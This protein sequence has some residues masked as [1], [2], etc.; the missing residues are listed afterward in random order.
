VEYQT[1]YNALYWSFV[2]DT[3]D[4][5]K[6]EAEKI[7]ILKQA[8]SIAKERATE[9]VLKTVGGG[10]S[11]FFDKYSGIEDGDLITFKTQIDLENDKDGSLNQ[12]ELIAIIQSMVDDGLSKE[13]AYTLF[14]SRYPNSDKNNPWRRYAP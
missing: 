8:Q 7:A 6:T 2:E 5:A 11:G 12:E 14:K 4:T 9:S 10:S 13:D 3:L 1:V